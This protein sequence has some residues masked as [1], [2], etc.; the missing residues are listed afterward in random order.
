MTLQELLI[1]VAPHLGAGWHVVTPEP[2]P[3]GMSYSERAATLSGPHGW[4]LHITCDAERMRVAG[5]YAGRRIGYYHHYKG[6]NEIG[7]S[8]ERPPLAI[9]RD[10][11]RRLLEKDYPA[12]FER[13]KTCAQAA[14][15]AEASERAMMERLMCIDPD[16]RFLYRD[17][18]EAIIYNQYV[19][20]RSSVG[21][22]Q[23]DR[24]EVTEAQALMILRIV[25]AGHAPR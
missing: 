3:E 22:V 15:S 19:K 24:L 20:I 13:A 14:A 18:Q 7:L 10:I 6:I 11:K 8:L 12:L 17:H 9:A 25:A 4:Q 1:Q 16:A 21:H 2:L 23:F 5:M